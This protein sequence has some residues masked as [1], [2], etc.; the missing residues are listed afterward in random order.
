MT[1]GTFKTTYWRVS[2]NHKQE[3]KNHKHELPNS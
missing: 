3:L 2:Q 1:D